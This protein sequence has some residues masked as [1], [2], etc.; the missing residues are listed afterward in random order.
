M[1][2]TLA[3]GI[4]RSVSMAPNRLKKNIRKTAT[5]GNQESGDNPSISPKL[6]RIK[7]TKITIVLI[8]LGLLV[9]QKLFFFSK[10]AFFVLLALIG[11]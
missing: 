9:P 11:F 7:Y 10:T 2:Q 1:K 5:R 6:T 4:N 3:T 8:K